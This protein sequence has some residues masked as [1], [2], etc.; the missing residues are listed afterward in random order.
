V[1]LT[2]P[3]LLQFS[4]I[5]AYA[6]ELLGNGLSTAYIQF[7]QQAYFFSIAVLAFL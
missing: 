1:A 3:V 2:T 5:R 6:Y 4:A 7:Y